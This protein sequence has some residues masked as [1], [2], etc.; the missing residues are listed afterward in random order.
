MSKHF[1]IDVKKLSEYCLNEKHPVGKHKAKVFS[2]ALDVTKQDAIQLKRII[3][4]KMDSA[5]L[6]LE[7]ED[8]YGKRFSSI[9]K[10]DI[11]DKSAFVKII[12]LHTSEKDFV[13]LITCYVI[14]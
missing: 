7:F 8:Q 10:V 2:S 6:T 1:K 4:S 11:K 12:W 5:D 14:D 9:I 3:L 13:R